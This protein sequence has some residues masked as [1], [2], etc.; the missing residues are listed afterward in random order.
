MGVKTYDSSTISAFPD[1]FKME[2]PEGFRI[3]TEYDDDMNEV[4]HLRGGFFINDDGDE[5]FGFSGS[6]IAFNV[7][8]TGEGDRTKLQD[9]SDPEFILNQVSKGIMENLQEK[10]G[11][12][13]SLKLYNSFPSAT[14]MKFYQPIQF[15]G[16]T[17][18]AYI[19]MVLVEVNENTI[20]GF[21]TVYQVD[22]AG[23]E[24]FY[25]HLLDVTKSIRV[26]GKPIDTGKLTPK[27]LEKALDMELDEDAEAL[28]LGLS[29]GINFKNGDEELQYTI[30]SDGSITS[31]DGEVLPPYD[32]DEEADS[33]SDAFASN[34]DYKEVRFSDDDNRTVIVDNKWSFKLPVGV[35]LKFDTEHM[36]IMGSN[37]TAQYVLLGMNQNG[38]D[39]FDFELHTR[40]DFGMGTDL[41]VLGCRHDNDVISGNAQQRIILDGDDLFVDFVNKSI[42]FTRS[43]VIIRVR[44]ED[45]RPWDFVMGV[46]SLDEDQTSRWDDIKNLMNELAGSIRLLDG[47]KQTAKKKKISSKN[48]ASDPDFIVERGVLRKYIG[49]K[50][51][52]VI[53]DGVKEIA[54]STFSGFSKL[55][56]VV[57]PEGVKRIGDRCFENC[58]NLRNCYLPDSLEE[59]GGY[60]FV[61]CRK[62]KELYLSDNI[63]AIGGSAFSE[64]F[65][66]KDIKIPK[67]IRAIDSFTFKNCDAFKH[68]VIPKGV[69]SI[70]FSAF[71]GCDDMEY[72]FIPE[73]VTDISVDFMENHPFAGSEKM[74][75]YTPAGSYAQ[76]FADE[77][78]IPYRNED[79]GKVTADNTEVRSESTDARSKSGDSAAS[80]EGLTYAPSD[81]SIYPHYN[82]RDELIAALQQKGI[83]PDDIAVSNDVLPAGTIIDVNNL[84][85][86]EE[87]AGL[88]ELIDYYGT[89]ITAEEAIGKT[90]KKKT[91][92]ITAI[93]KK[94]LDMSISP[95]D[96]IPD[97]HN[98]SK[99]D[100][101]EMIDDMRSLIASQNMKVQG[102]MEYFDKMEEREKKEKA[103]RK[104][105][106]E[107]AASA[108]KSETDKTNLFIV[109]CN[110]TKINAK[111]MTASKFNRLYG[112]FFPAYTKDEL[113]A[114]RKE[115]LSAMKDEDRCKYYYEDFRK[116]PIEDR[117]DIA[118]KSLFVR[119]IN[120]NHDSVRSS[121]QALDI[122]SEWFTAD[123]MVSVEKMLKNELMKL[124]NRITEQF[125]WAEKEWM[126]YSTAKKYLE[127]V[128][129]YYEDARDIMHDDCKM[130]QVKKLCSIGY[131]F[132]AVVL[133]Q[134]G[135]MPL[136]VPVM[137]HASYYWGV[138]QSEIW[139]D[140]F[141][142]NVRNFYKY[143]DDEDV[144]EY[145]RE[146]I[147]I[148]SNDYPDA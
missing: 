65:V 126:D 71:A 2:L 100:V 101:I 44:G 52:I 118:T 70:G 54:D 6:F 75:I 55:E 33:F 74:T 29:V 93:S 89:P 46:S 123:E 78:G 45:L 83:K 114:A 62:L 18:D 12:G 130:F 122:A 5:T 77:K 41:D 147:R 24:D 26:N 104:K 134:K 13:K 28:D 125:S 61:D 68:I 111:G 95:N 81:E 103:E 115:M 87:I 9:R 22:S 94:M 121:K 53:P 69:E 108:E 112:D 98:T 56:S 92:A 79:N 143:L 117:F 20:Y 120:D 42:F 32:P 82:S 17:L 135:L 106:K 102:L 49:K 57:V 3:D 58:I 39:Y 124:N 99:I 51:D 4:Y 91:K 40:F 90:L 59:V 36:D 66:L 116:R 142:N 132:Y 19:F 144:P 85:S 128:I 127:I 7:D 60:A 137:D 119:G 133:R 139:K 146:A 21:N 31:P 16:V 88:E 138:P 10:F 38:K 43:M 1:G 80:N 148:A 86:S 141:N 11:T 30:N 96:S 113:W 97:D 110:E 136:V 84:C 8:I 47:A 145:A 63:K 37:T 15:F 67:N 35:D 64:C 107:Q 73:S 48:E 23:S 14:I 72:L 105:K 109:V 129:Y 140:A 25:K 76:K 34:D 131:L 50:S 27:K